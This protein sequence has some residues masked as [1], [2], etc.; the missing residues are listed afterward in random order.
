MPV[1]LIS[2]EWSFS[3]LSG[4]DIPARLLSQSLSTYQPEMEEGED[5]E[6]WTP[7]MVEP[8][9]QMLVHTELSSYGLNYHIWH[10][11]SEAP[12]MTMRQSLPVTLMLGTMECSIAYPVNPRTRTCFDCGRPLGLYL[13]SLENSD[14]PKGYCAPCFLM[15]YWRKEAP[16]TSVGQT[17]GVDAYLTSRVEETLKVW[18]RQ[19]REWWEIQKTALSPVYRHFA[20]RMGVP[21]PS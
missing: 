21:L 15:R 13:F 19:D 8:Y 7:M 2:L 6:V 10:S 1:K 20:L 14:V 3:L 5:E 18:N 12:R 4:Q 17:H 9:P 16:T 11:L